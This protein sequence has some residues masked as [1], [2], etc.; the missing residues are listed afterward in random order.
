MSM[1]LTTNLH[2]HLHRFGEIIIVAA[3]VFVAVGPRL[4]E[5]GITYIIGLIG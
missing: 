2:P 4:D 1:R 5:L 3:A